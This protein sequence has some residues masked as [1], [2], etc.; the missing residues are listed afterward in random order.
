MGDTKSY[1]PSTYFAERR[2]IR[3]LIGY[4]K[5][6]DP[7]YRK[8]NVAS[9]ASALE[10]LYGKTEYLSVAQWIGDGML[11]AERARRSSFWFGW[12]RAW[13]IRQDVLRNL[14][15]INFGNERKEN[16]Q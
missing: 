10:L 2:K 12:W 1:N 4:L 16:R 3:E 5:R 6:D 7:Q 11:A 14:H 9:A 8:Q 15:R 13:R